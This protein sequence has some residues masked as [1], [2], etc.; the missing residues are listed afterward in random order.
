MEEFFERLNG[1]HKKYS[2]YFLMLL[3]IIAVV[4]AFRVLPYLIALFLPFVIGWVVSF[5][6]SPMVKFL[7]KKL[8]VPYRICAI[9]T[10]LLLLTRYMPLFSIVGTFVCGIPLAALGDRL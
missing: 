3:L 10:V 2:R 1:F 5:I 8:H 9:I 4:V 7:K 6:A